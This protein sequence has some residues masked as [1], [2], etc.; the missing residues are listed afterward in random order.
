MADSTAAPV[1]G[2]QELA[3]GL[4][5]PLA[6]AINNRLKVAPAT[7]SHHANFKHGGKD[8]KISRVLV[9]SGALLKMPTDT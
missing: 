6:N 1:I 7:G 8:R 2:N 9:E 3:L 5:I 4:E